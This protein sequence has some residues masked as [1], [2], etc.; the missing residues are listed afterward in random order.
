[1]DY[2][3][4]EMKK[5]NKYL[6]LGSIVILK[7]GSKKIMIYGRQQYQLSSDKILWDYV[8]CLYPEG[9]IS[10][11]YN[12]F[13]NHNDIEKT[14]YRGFEDDEEKI[15]QKKIEAFKYSVQLDQK[16]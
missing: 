4:K 3:S 11:D 15:Y 14:I 5:V 9:F 10:D 1:M 12:I 7:G 16:I 8:G 2:A 13:F 6:S